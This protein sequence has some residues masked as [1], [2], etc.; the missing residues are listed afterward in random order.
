MVLPLDELGTDW[1]LTEE[2]AEPGWYR[3]TLSSGITAEITVGPKSA[4]HRYTFGAHKNARVV[5]DLSLGGLS[6]PYG[7]TVRCAPT[8]T[9][10]RTTWRR[11]RSSSK[12][13]RSPSTWSATR[14]AGGSCSGTTAA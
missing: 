7:A 6:I 11:A 2:R 13:H 10:S 1:E 4:V 9:R 5:V 14:P 12:A 8:C 3:A